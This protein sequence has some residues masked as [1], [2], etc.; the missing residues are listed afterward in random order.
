[1]RRDSPIEP[2]DDDIP[3]PAG[4]VFSDC[5]AP[6]ITRKKLTRGWGYYDADGERITERA[7]IDRL[8]AIGLPPAYRD[9]WFCPDPIGHI[10]AIGWDEKGRKQY[11]YHVDFR[12][13]Q[14]SAK[15][16]R[17]AAFGHALPK[18]RA[19]VEQNL[20]K[21]TLSRD[22][23]VAA[24]VRLLDLGR[25]RVGNEG[26]ARVNKSFGA[27]TLRKRHAKL[28]GTK[29][30]LQ[31]RAK[32]GKMRVLTITDR[33]LASFVRKCQDLPGQ[34]LFR[35]VDESGETHPVTS[36]DVNAYIRAAM[37][38]DFTAKHFRTWGASVLA[39]T[40]LAEADADITL[41]TMLGPVVDALGN[42]PAIARKSY[43][44]PLLIDLVKDG[45]SAFRDTL[46]LPRTVKYLS[47]HERGLIALLEAQ[48]RLPA[49]A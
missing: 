32:S 14:E 1:M 21:R 43:V 48:E 38:G 26:Y 8:N 33:S 41:K 37:G 35:W 4:C 27:T 29:L 23:A 5:D 16:D 22:R 40:T 20:A 34:H 31:Y 46:R 28:A 7:E 36:S 15:Y 18:L 6:G 44:H 10:Q 11:R 45:Q 47:R 9:A 39:F 25:V 30:R 2:A 13:A 24:V 42:T 3:C 49:A 17:C 19:Q 12:A